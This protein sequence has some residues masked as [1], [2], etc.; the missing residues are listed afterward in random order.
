MSLGQDGPPTRTRMPEGHGAQRGGTGRRQPPRRALVTV[1]SVVV[2]L[3]AAIAFANRGGPARSPDTAGSGDSAGAGGNAKG[4]SAVTA[5]APSGQRPVGGRTAGIPSGF[6]HT[7]QGAQSAAAN[8]AVALGGTDMFAAT[9]RHRIVDTVYAAGVTARLQ[10]ELD[11]AYSASSITGLGLNAD[12]TAPAG[13]TFVSRTVPVGTK[14]LA[15]APD[16]VTAGVW[17]T[18]LSG[19]AGK[20]STKPVTTSWFTITEK[21]VW[22]SGDWKIQSSSQKEGPAPVSG[23]DQVATADQIAGAVQQYG[24][25]TYAR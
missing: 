25:F 4:D 23:D 5:T 13:L 9:S 8:Y 17:C 12:G 1:V 15:S 22:D 2:L 19:F 14:I 3:V 18:A 16:A 24:G 20:S 11:G 10:T 7:A 21:L 6:A